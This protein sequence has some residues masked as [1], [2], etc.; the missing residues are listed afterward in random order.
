MIK[1]LIVKMNVRK[2]WIVKM[3]MRTVMMT[4]RSHR[5][6]Q[7]HLSGDNVVH[8][9]PVSNLI[10]KGQDRDDK[11]YH[12]DEHIGDNGGYKSQ[13]KC[14]FKQLDCGHDMMSLVIV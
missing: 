14:A 13:R 5:R 6:H 11:H 1:I 9:G 7:L 12:D 3:T 2:V 4:M 10:I 8:C